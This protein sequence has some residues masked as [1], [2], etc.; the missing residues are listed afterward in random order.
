ML[1]SELGNAD[2]VAHFVAEC[3]A[4]GLGVL[5]PDVN[6][7]REMFTPVGGKIRFGLGGVK[8]VGE[9]AA[10]RI[11]EEREANGPYSDF[12]DFASRVD[13]R[14]VN[15]R[16][17]EHLVKTGAFDFSRASRRR[18]FEAIDAAMAAGNAKARDKAAGQETFLGILAGPAK[19]N[20]AGHR[21][22][23]TSPDFSAHERLSFEKELLGFYVSGH[24]MNSY[25]GIWEA[26]DTAPADGLAGLPDREE[27]RLCGIAGNIVK[28]YAKKD[29]R[30]WAAF[31]LATRNSTIA[32]NMFADAY[33]AFGSALAENAPLLVQGNLIRGADGPRLNVKECYETRP[34]GRTD[35]AQGDMAP[36]ARAPRHR[37]LPARAPGDGRPRAGGHEARVCDAPRRRRCA[38]RRGERRPLVA[39]DGGGVPGPALPALRR[40]GRA[41]RAAARI[42]AGRSM[43]ETLENHAARVLGLI[44]SGVPA[45]AALREYLPGHRTLGPSGSAPSAARSSRISAGSTG[46]RR[47]NRRSAGSSG[48]WTSRRAS[49]A[50]PQSVKAEALAA[51]AVP[52]WL[53]GGD[54]ALARLPALPPGRALALDP[55]EGRDRRA[56]G[57]DLGDCEAAK[58]SSSLLCAARALRPSVQGDLGPPQ[59]ARLPVRGIRDPG[60]LVAARG[61]RLR[62]E[63]RRDLVGRLRRR[64]RQGAPSF[65]PDGEQG[66]PLDDG[67]VRAPARGPQEA[68]SAGRNVQLPPGGLDG[69]G[70]RAVQDEVR[71]RPRRRAHAAVSAPGSATRTRAG[72]RPSTTSAS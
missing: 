12:E 50:I 1:S 34:G 60:P 58:A 3:E 4:M 70:D 57:A 14:A 20:G 65:R 17:L 67:Q 2:K 45:D 48:R 6:E 7:S 61:A 13:G 30:P 63:T 23:E 10:Q 54:G 21:E 41:R 8:G 26:I 15:K 44:R 19:R 59:G 22:P 64:G 40:G 5:G 28:K 68:R 31:T 33:A 24:P 25:S 69:S 47:R 39:P 43:G 53:C 32:L 46:S 16:V 71:R 35:R 72:R 51:R 38:G 56:G 36:P 29:N 55:G 11:I 52:G 49:T 62:P 37:V 9:L 66:P 27:F 18:I 42:E